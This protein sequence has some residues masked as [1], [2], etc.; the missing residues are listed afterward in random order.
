[1][2]QVTSLSDSFKQDINHL[3]LIINKNE[4][5]RSKSREQIFSAD[6]FLPSLEANLEVLKKNIFSVVEM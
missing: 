2:K 3:K 5:E 4:R 6:K 1:V